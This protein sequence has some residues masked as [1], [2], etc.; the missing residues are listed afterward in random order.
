ME[1]SFDDLQKEGIIGSVLYWTRLLL[2]VIPVAYIIFLIYWMAITGQKIWINAV[3]GGILTTC[4]FTMFMSIAS[5]VMLFFVQFNILQSMNKVFKYQIFIVVSVLTLFL[6]CIL[7]GI[8]TYDK[9]SQYSSDISDYI[10]RNIQDS[11]VVEFMAEY[12]TVAS[13]TSYVLK[14]TTEA[15]DVNAVFFALW[16]VALFIVILANHKIEKNNSEELLADERYYQNANPNEA[17][18]NQAGDPEKPKEQ[19]KRTRGQN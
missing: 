9:A 3:G 18:P 13:R 10:Q 17:D 12:S 6:S 1:K 16:A 5:I 4:L 15:Y 19:P 2:V 11:K 8:T 14:R 7:L